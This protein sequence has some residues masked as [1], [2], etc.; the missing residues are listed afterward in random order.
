MYGAGEAFRLTGRALQA[1]LHQ[2]AGSGAEY[3]GD[4]DPKGIRIPVDFDHLAEIG[5]LRVRPAQVLY[6]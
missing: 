6:Q 1:A 4:L 2:V 5:S 3:L